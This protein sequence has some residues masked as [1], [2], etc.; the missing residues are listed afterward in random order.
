[1]MQSAEV[2]RLLHQALLLLDSCFYNSKNKQHNCVN[3]FVLAL[4]RMV[5]SSCHTW[6]KYVVCC[7][8][9]VLLAS[10]M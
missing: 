6:L 2:H 10:Y 8:Q 4:H 7:I 9:L 1:M 5:A 3:S